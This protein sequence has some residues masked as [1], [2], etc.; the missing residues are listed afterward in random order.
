MIR[1][2]GQRPQ[3]PNNISL[4]IQYQLIDSDSIE[5]LSHPPSLCGWPGNKPRNTQGKYRF[6]RHDRA[7]CQY[8]EDANIGKGWLQIMD[9]TALRYVREMERL[10][11][12][13]E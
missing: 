11:Q 1:G 4:S 5:L 10:G 13:I 3:F 8:R 12:D 2:Y 6:A 7:R 9:G